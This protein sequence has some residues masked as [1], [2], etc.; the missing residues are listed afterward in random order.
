MS[1]LRSWRNSS[2]SRDLSEYGIPGMDGLELYLRTKELMYNVP[3]VIFSTRIK[4][5]TIEDAL[6]VGVMRALKRPS[7]KVEVLSVV[8]EA[9]EERQRQILHF[10]C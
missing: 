9:I 8:A 5:Q 10:F 7:D 4:S 2:L 3:L 1:L 6:K